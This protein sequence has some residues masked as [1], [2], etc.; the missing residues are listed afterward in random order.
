MLE[1]LE[2]GDGS[3]LAE[4]SRAGRN[5]ALLGPELFAD[6]RVLSTIAALWSV[7]WAF[8]MR[9]VAGGAMVGVCFTM[10]P[11]MENLNVRV[12]CMFLDPYEAEPA[13]RR[14]VQL[15]FMRYPLH[16]LLAHVPIFMTDYVEVYQRAG[17][18]MEGVLR[19]HRWV[20]GQ[21]QNVALMGLLRQ[22]FI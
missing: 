13:V 8:P 11:D 22:E 17:F 20:G 15:L 18:V 12:A 14:Y 7:L 21:P 5:M 4:L 9:W 1:P 16:R 3:A 6:T 2:P 10:E 19:D